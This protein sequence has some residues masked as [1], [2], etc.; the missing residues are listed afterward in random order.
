MKHATTYSKIDQRYGQAQ[1]N[2][3]IFQTTPPA[4]LTLSLAFFGNIP[5]TEDTALKTRAAD[6]KQGQV[7][8]TN[9]KRTRD[10]KCHE[11]AV[12]ATGGVFGALGGITSSINNHFSSSGDPRGRETP[13]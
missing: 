6:I 5:K 8:A 12:G 1:T 13:D 7:F 11:I 9:R 10:T 4:K 2:G 3:R